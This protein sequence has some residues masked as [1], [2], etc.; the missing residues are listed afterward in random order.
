MTLDAWIDLARGPLFRLSLAA[1]VLGLAYHVVATLQLFLVARRRA[2]HRALPYRAIAGRTLAW[3][4]PWRILRSRPLYGA[5]SLIFHAAVLLVP[6]FYLGHV[7]L[8]GGWLPAG[9]PV[10][11]GGVADALTWAG[12]AGLALLLG[13]RLLVAR[14]RQ[15]TRF[16]DAAILAVLL[17][18]LLSGYWAA[19]PLAA[20]VL[21][22]RAMVLAHML[23]ADLVLLLLPVSK[24]VHVVLY[25]FG[26]LLSEIGWR[27]PAASGRHVA[28]A[29]NKENEPV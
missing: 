25:P 16:S 27:F 7:G 26:Q 28:V 29:L 15:L 18:T 6:L 5:A 10:L 1:C 4:G 2:A 20:P 24:M 8:L 22:P 23:L 3:L 13:G 12:I 9:W 19:H 11:P 21:P 17:A 14:S